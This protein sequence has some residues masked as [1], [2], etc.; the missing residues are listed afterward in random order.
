MAL[1]S[2][3]HTKLFKHKTSTC[4]GM[5]QS[6]PLY[7]TRLGNSKLSSFLEISRFLDLF[8]RIYYP[9]TYIALAGGGGDSHVTRTGMFGVNSKENLQKIPARSLRR[10]LI[11][12][13]CKT[14]FDGTKIIKTCFI[15]C[16]DPVLWA[17]SW[18]FFPLNILTSRTGFWA[19]CSTS[20][21]EFEKYLMSL[22]AET[23]RRVIPATKF[24]FFTSWQF[25]IPK[26]YRF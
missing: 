3:S 7:S 26:S 11:F 6:V 10:L 12:L 13:I 21:L 25:F 23:Q 24:K 17:S 19:R 8:R 2:G 1:R 5:R 14:C 22:L 4:I 9:C 20:L 18:N 16:Q 15:N